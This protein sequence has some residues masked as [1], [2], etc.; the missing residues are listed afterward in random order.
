MSYVFVSFLNPEYIPGLGN[1]NFF[2]VWI[3]KILVGT[4]YSLAS[5]HVSFYQNHLPSFSIP[6]SV[7]TRESPHLGRGFIP[8][9]QV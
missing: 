9:S 7:R 4:I 6:M 2:V 3:T 1:A 5:W 8:T